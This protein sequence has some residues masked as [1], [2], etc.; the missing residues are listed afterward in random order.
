MSMGVGPVQ[1]G[2]VVPPRVGQTNACKNITFARFATRA[3]KIVRFFIEF[4]ISKAGVL[5]YKL[6]IYC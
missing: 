4:S 1:E 2:G 5:V 3:V 6:I